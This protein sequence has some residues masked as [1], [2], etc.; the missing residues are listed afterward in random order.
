M[1]I[2][3]PGVSELCEGNPG[4]MKHYWMDFS[5]NAGKQQTGEVVFWELKWRLTCLKYGGFYTEKQSVERR[6]VSENKCIEDV[7]GN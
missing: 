4:E 1:E 2:E 5:F 7:G 6:Q 3:F